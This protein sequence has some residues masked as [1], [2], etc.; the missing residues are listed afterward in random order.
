MIW[1]IRRIRRM[2]RWIKMVFREDQNDGQV[3]EDDGQEDQN[4]GRTWFGWSHCYQIYFSLSV[5]KLSSSLEGWHLT[6]RQNK[7]PIWKEK[8]GLNSPNVPQ[9]IPKLSP[10]FKSL[11]SVEKARQ[12]SSH[13]KGRKWFD[14][15]IA[16][17]GPHAPLSA[18]GVTWHE[19]HLT[20]QQ[21]H[22]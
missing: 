19:Q 8:C 9:V 6:K 7:A 12:A 20:L 13:M 21:I 1:R 11:A 3:D 4:D 14:V 10:S 5:P 22:H 15:W 16:H 18:D 2:F 17:V